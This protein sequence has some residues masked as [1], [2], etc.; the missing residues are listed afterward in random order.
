M[1]LPLLGLPM[2]VKEQFRS[3]RQAPPHRRPKSRR[4]LPIEFGSDIGGP[5]RA[6][7]H[8]CGVFS[9]KHLLCA[10]SDAPLIEFKAN[11][12]AACAT[13]RIFAKGSEP[14]VRSATR[15]FAEDDAWK[16]ISGR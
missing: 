15:N 8:F 10:G 5:L 9:H 4:A 1:L 6:P 13:R 16:V 14:L 7:A 2:T 12:T 11:I 3:R